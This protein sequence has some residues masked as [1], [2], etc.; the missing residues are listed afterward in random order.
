MALESTT[1]SFTPIETLR[2][3]IEYITKKYMQE[4][5]DE[6]NNPK[7]NTY[8]ASKSAATVEDLEV[9]IDTVTIQNENKEIIQL[10]VLDK[11][12]HEFIGL[13]VIKK[14][15]NGHPEISLWT[16]E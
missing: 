13:C 16:K 4:I 8:L 3:K 15:N 6:K 5:F 1:W 11:E 14:P 9:F 7:V 10:Q 2:L 12:T